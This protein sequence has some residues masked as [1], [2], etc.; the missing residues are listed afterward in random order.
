[1]SSTHICSHAAL[2]FR[3]R[4]EYLQ[5]RAQVSLVFCVLTQA[6]YSTGSSRWAPYSG[7]KW[8]GDGKAIEAGFLHR[9]CACVAALL[10]SRHACALSPDLKIKQLYHTAWTAKE[11][12]PTDIQNVVQ[13]KDGYLWIATTAGLFRFD[14]V[15]FERIDAI[16]G[17]RL[18]STSVYML[19]APP[20]GGL[21]VGY[22]FGG[23]SLISNGRITNYGEREGLPVGSVRGFAQ[24]NAGS[25]WVAT[26][27][28]LRRFDGSQWIDIGA[29]LG[30]PK[31]YTS[32]VASDRSG[33]L[34][35]EVNNSIM[36]L[37]PGQRT[38]A[39][40]DIRL[41]GEIKFLEGPDGTLWLIDNAK[42]ARALYVPAGSR[43]PGNDWLPLGGT[44]LG[45]IDVIVIARDGTFWESTPTGI[46][47]QR[48]PRSSLRPKLPHGAA[49]DIFWLS[50]GLTGP[51]SP[52]DS[53]G[54]EDREGNVWI[55]TA[56]GLDRFRESRL[57]RVDLPASSDGFALAPGENGTMLVGAY[58]KNG[59]FKVTGGSVVEPVSGPRDITCA[60]RDADGIIWLGG[61]E[62]IWYSAA[63]RWI[64]IELPAPNPVKASIPGMQA[65]TKDRTGT[66]WVSVAREGVF[67]L[68]DGKWSRYGEAATT[69]TTDHDGR[70]WLGYPN[71]QVQIVD[72]DT[73]QR[74][75]AT[76]GLDIGP[77][78]SIAAHRRYIWVG[79]ERGLARFDGRRFHAVTRRGSTPLPRISGIIENAEGDLWLS[80]SEGAMKVPAEQVRQVVSDSN[81][82]VQYTLLDFLDGMPGTPAAVRPLPTMVEGTDGRLWFAT[83]NGVAWADP[84]HA[85][86][87]MLKPTVDVQ[88]IIADGVR[89][90]PSADLRLPIR[91]RNLQ[92]H[93]TALSLS[94][95]ERVR[96]RYQLG[97][98]QPWQDVGPRRDAYF[99]NLAPGHYRFRVIASNND[100]VWNETGAAVDF[101][102]PP[103]FV[104][105]RWFLALCASAAALVLWVLWTLRL[106]QIQ[107]RLWDRHEARLLERERI[108][109]ELHDTLLQ[110]L[111][112][113]SLQLAV[114]DSEISPSA[115]AKPLVERVSRLLRQI[116]DEGRNAVRGLRTGHSDR[117][118]LERAFAQIP[119]D[120]AADTSINYALIV[121]G[122]PRS[123]RPLIRSEV[124]RIGREALANA[125][126]HSRASVIET[127]L[128][129]SQD[130]FRMVVRDNGL[131][132]DPEVLRCGREGHW[133]LSGM[134]ER[135]QKIGARL[136]VLSAAGA[137]TEIDLTIPG[138]AAFQRTASR[139]SADWLAKIY[140]LSEEQ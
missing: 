83:S 27:R 32:M 127:V 74:L 112:S 115:T 67:R 51:V 18:S 48:D 61:P 36:F 42:G 100:G 70:V 41:N 62:K 132:I 10:L 87:N 60:Y 37:H 81:H 76:D 45:P 117:D 4:E 140:S 88:S 54:L 77:V 109:Q 26:S 86:R 22:A 30:L 98:N 120:L 69:L 52:G 122:T 8:R 65:I 114:A 93:Y 19:W 59:A 97:V 80:T 126:R 136:K 105:T 44:R 35:I 138:G 55:G 24:D 125:F 89:Y 101:D 17:Q 13:T 79:G 111:L 31:T 94:V 129:Y 113:A 123:L 78:L 49:A 38:F 40:A 53:S 119:E 135:S 95:P 23:V 96:F 131:G 33:T 92:I 104:Q 39:A 29:E 6:M 106:R 71:S 5:S 72:T 56:G 25:I 134:R 43:N 103:A 116:I 58:S 20:S 139:G 34:W 16:R 85:T 99:T 1:V 66:L 12:A 14:G 124:Y 84:R 28:G 108:A 11:G 64:G 133:G 9:L 90:E 7:A 91:T 68:V 130:R 102:I 47:R 3:D 121:E 110:G 63:Q 75:S 118:D 107:A 21:W 137:G 128:D 46:R 73:V 50:D 2:S 82:A 15:R 57:T